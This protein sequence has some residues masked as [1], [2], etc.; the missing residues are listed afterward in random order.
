[1]ERSED[2]SSP[3][4]LGRW[5]QARGTTWVTASGWGWHVKVTTTKTRRRRPSHWVC[6]FLWWI[7]KTELV[8]ED[9]A[10]TATWIHNGYTVDSEGSCRQWGEWNGRKFLKQIEM[11]EQS[12]D[13]C[14]RESVDRQHM[15]GHC[16]RLTRLPSF[17]FLVTVWW[18][19][20]AF[21]ILW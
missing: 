6:M 12:S 10:T 19:Q 17:F 18:P 11:F 4:F 8:Q 2:S 7:F 14:P 1:M 16:G 13:T 20:D 15:D 21:S 3:N 5:K 9:W